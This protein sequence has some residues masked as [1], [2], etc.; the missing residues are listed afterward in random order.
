MK[1][2]FSQV[3]QS[4]ALSALIPGLL[5]SVMADFGHKVKPEA[6]TEQTTIPETRPPQSEE[7]SI[8]I[9]V[10]KNGKVINMELEEYICRVVL[11]EMPASFETEALKAQAVAARTYALRC[12]G[13]STHPKGAVCTSHKCC[14]SYCE[15]EGYIRNGGT[16]DN[17]QKVFDAVLQ[18]CG[19]VLYYNDKLIM[20]TYFSSAGGTTEDAK[21]VWGNAYP[22]L[23]VVSS[24]EEDD[25]FNGETVTFSAKEFQSLLGVTLKGKPTGWFGAVTY[26]VGGGVDQIRIGGTLYSGVQLRSLLSLRSTDFSVNTTDTSVTFTTNGYGHRVGMSQYGADAMAA[27]GSDYTQILYHYY[28]GTTLGQYSAGGD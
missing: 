5:F 9:P 17:V 3:I 7:E 2:F 18:T 28:T 13:G 23:T 27:A 26:T 25:R 8:K 22:Y 12:I 20:A 14:Q 4:V 10:L 16:W 19:Q 21:A 15:P 1:L 24:P 11:G 6:P